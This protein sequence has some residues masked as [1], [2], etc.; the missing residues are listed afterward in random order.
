MTSAC[1]NVHSPNPTKPEFLA[2][3]DIAGYNYVD[4][5]GIHREIYFSDDREKYPARKFVGTED[6][7]RGAGCAGRILAGAA[8]LARGGAGGG[9]NLFGYASSMVRAEQLWK[10]NA[11][12]DYV[13]GYFMW[14]GIDYLGE[15]GAWPRKGASSGV[16]DVCGFPKDGYYF[17][18][19][20]WGPADE[21]VV[22]VLPHWNYPAGKRGR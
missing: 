4:R 11:V 2:A 19:S 13:I 21:P 3:L 6:V 9:G 14:T 7:G 15:A 12:H 8:G 18:K 1:D 17:Y 22:H 16:L 5:W 10:F 20:Q